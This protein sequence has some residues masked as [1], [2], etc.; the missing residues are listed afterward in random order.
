MSLS[1]VEDVMLHGLSYDPSH[2]ASE[3]S[4]TL[5]S[6]RKG[7]VE[8]PTLSQHW[9]RF[10]N[11]ANAFEEQQQYRP[12]R[13]CS[14]AIFDHSSILPS[15]EQQNEISWDYRC[16]NGMFN[17]YSSQVCPRSYPMDNEAI[18]QTYLQPNQPTYEYPFGSS[19][20]MPGQFLHQPNASFQ[21]PSTD[22]FQN[23]RLGNNT[24]QSSLGDDLVPSCSSTIASSPSYKIQLRY[25]ANPSV[26]PMDH[27]DGFND[28]VINMEEDSEGDGGLNSEPYARLIW[29]ALKSAPEHKMVLKEIY[30]WVARNTDKSKDPISKGWQNSIRHNLSMNGVCGRTVPFSFHTLLT[31]CRRSRRLSNRHPLKNRRKVSSG[32]L[33]LPR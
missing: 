12:N 10:Q 33:R 17:A 3:A 14:S 27:Y 7:V 21:P 9:P 23:L 28:G 26:E 13:D 11:S 24:P 32:F 5:D 19:A 15:V 29:R 6:H 8:V 31:P 22:L 30:D 20:S 4:C 1:S 18:L 2:G 16:A 25:S